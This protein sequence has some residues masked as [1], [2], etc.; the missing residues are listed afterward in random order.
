ML[1]DME[2]HLYMYTDIFS[3]GCRLP[4][5]KTKWLVFFYVNVRRNYATCLSVP[6]LK[7]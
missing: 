2:T 5:L 1:L 3:H 7:M 4:T 6:L